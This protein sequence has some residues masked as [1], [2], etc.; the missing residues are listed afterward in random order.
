M[1][2]LQLCGLQRFRK[3]QIERDEEVEEVV[4]EKLFEGLGKVDALVKEA[5]FWGWIC[6]YLTP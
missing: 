2:D 6:N 5:A 4:L 3:E 1:C